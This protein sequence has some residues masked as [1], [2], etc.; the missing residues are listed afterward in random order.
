MKLPGPLPFFSFQPTWTTKTPTKPGLYRYKDHSDGEPI[1][2]SVTEIDGVVIAI[3]Q[4]RLFAHPKGPVDG[5]D[6]AWQGP[7]AMPSEKFALRTWTL[8]RPTQVN[9]TVGHAMLI[10]TTN[11]PTE[12][13]WYS[14]R[15]EG[16]NAVPVAVQVE[17]ASDTIGPWDEGNTRR[18]SEETGEWAGPLERP[19]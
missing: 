12:A 5:L 13:G 9:G 6:G 3:E 15:L 10:W 16:L 8:G 11:K 18:L 7:L 14:H 2:V 17:P 1:L 4:S 19:A